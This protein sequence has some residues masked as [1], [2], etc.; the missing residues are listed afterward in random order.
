[1]PSATLSVSSSRSRLSTRGTDEKRHFTAMGAFEPA[2]HLRRTLLLAVIGISVLSS[3]CITESELSLSQILLLSEF[4]GPTNYTVIENNTLGDA[5]DMMFYIE[6]RDFG[7][8]RESG[9]YEFWVSID[10]SVSDWEGVEYVS[11]INER[12]I[13][14]TNETEKPGMVWYTYAWNTGGVLRTGEYWVK[15]DVK[16]KISNRIATAERTFYID[17]SR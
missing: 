3:G 14:R 9:T 1:M 2:A 16:D 7:V 8:K 15:I 12:E 11:K 4:Y 10:I 5:Q 17:L 6:V 13:H